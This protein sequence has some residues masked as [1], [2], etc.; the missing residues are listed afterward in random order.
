MEITV[1]GTESL[2]VRGLS[3]VVSAG[4]R[5]ILIDPGV[6]L[7]YL[8]RGRLPHPRQVAVGAAVRERV[9]TEVPIA[10]DIVISHYHGDHVPLAEANPYQ[11]PLVRLPPPADGA[12]LWCKGPDGLSNLSLRRRDDIAAYLKRDLPPAEET[13]DA[14]LHFSRP[15]FHGT[16]GAHTGRVMM[17]C[18]RDG[19]ETFVHA[20]DIQMLSR[21]AI[22]IITDWA[23]DTVLAS[24]P[25]LYLHLLS[26]EDAAAARANAL[27]LA[28]SV[29][30]LILDHH[31]LRSRAGWRWLE[32]LA[33]EAE[34]R[35]CSAAAFMGQ[36]P[37]PMEADREELYEEYPVPH[38]WHDDYARGKAD[39]GAFVD[40]TLGQEIE[41]IRT[42]R[43]RRM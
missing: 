16:P 35:V 40:A 18:I 27:T 6:A 28:T 24:G 37:L 26:A 20:S 32:R 13:G 4:K 36:P 17:T 38:R 41:A 39:V 30:T 11:L 22:D 10:T 33:G 21:E 25:P 3:C 31:L 14:V 2:G 9:L 8:R 7:G 34:G 5:R 19:E 42:G 29:P 23:P 12:R 43:G 15:V 1:I